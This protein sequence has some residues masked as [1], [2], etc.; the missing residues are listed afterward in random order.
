MLT[1][2]YTGFVLGEGPGVLTGVLDL[3]TPAITTSPVGDYPIK[4]SSLSATNY[5]IAYKDGNL[6]VDPASSTPTTPTG[7]DTG[8]LEIVALQGGSR[9]SQSGAGAVDT[10]NT[11][12]ATGAGGEGE[13]GVPG[14]TEPAFVAG[15]VAIVVCGISLPPGV[16]PDSRCQLR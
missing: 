9:G 6:R 8:I 1:A 3:S 11:L 13:G 4:A 5:Q 16:E 15:D 10:L 7:N 14:P 2:S 12:P